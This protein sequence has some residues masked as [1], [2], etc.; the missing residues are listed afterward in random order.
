[1]SDSSSQRL[2]EDRG[3]E[4][5]VPGCQRA[6]LLQRGALGAIAVAQVDN[7]DQLGEVEVVNGVEILDSLLQV[8]YRGIHRKEGTFLSFPFRIYQGD[9]KV[10]VD[11]FRFPSGHQMLVPAVTKRVIYPPPGFIAISRHHLIA[12]LRFPILGFLIDMLNLLKLPPT[13]LIPSF[14]GQLLTLYLSFRK[15][16]IPPP[17][18]NVIRYCFTLKQC[19][20]AKGLSKDALHDGMHYLSVRA[21]EYKELL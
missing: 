19:Q 21:S 5:F 18:D 9:L 16:E 12:G 13:Q 6:R 17:N 7:R 8:T 11:S 15:N 4:A 3:A 2:H 10:M 14:Y 1:M 20:L